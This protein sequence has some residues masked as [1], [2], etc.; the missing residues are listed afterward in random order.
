MAPSP[1][2]IVDVEISDMQ[3]VDEGVAADPEK[4]V[5]AIFADRTR[6]APRPS[7]GACRVTI[8]GR[9]EST[10]QR[11]NGASTALHVMGFKPSVVL[12]ANAALSA[13]ARHVGCKVSE[14]RA[15]P[16]R[17]AMMDAWNP[18]PQ[19]LKARVHD[20]QRVFLPT[21]RLWRQARTFEG[22]I[23]S[24]VDPT[25]QFLAQTN[26]KASGW[27][28]STSTGRVTRCCHADVEHECHI[29]HVAPVDREDVA[30]L[31]QLSFDIECSSATYRF[32]KPAEQPDDHVQQ[33][34]M[35][36][37]H[38]G[39]PWES[40]RRVALCIAPCNDIQAT[41]TYVFANE[42][43]LLLGVRDWITQTNPDCIVQ[44]NGTQFDWK[45]LWKRAE[46]RGID[47]FAYL[48][49]ARLQ[50][51]R[52]DESMPKSKQKGARER[53]LPVTPGRV[54]IDLFDFM[55]NNRKLPSYKL[56]DIAELDL[57]ERKVD[58]SEGGENAYRVLNRIL[59]GA[60]GALRAKAMDYC[61]RDAELPLLLAQKNKVLENYANTSRVTHTMMQKVIVGGEG[62]KSTRINVRIMH[63]LDPPR[64]LPTLHS[65]KQEDA[66]YEGATVI[67]PKTGF[68]KQKVQALDFASLYPSIMLRYNL[69][70]STLV[71][72]A[73]IRAP[74]VRAAR[75][76]GLR[77]PYVYVRVDA[78]GECAVT[79]H[80][81]AAAA[82]EPAL[83]WLE[84]KSFLVVFCGEETVWVQD[85]ASVTG[86]VV[87]VLNGERKRVRTI[88]EDETD[89]AM[90]AVLDAQQKAFKVSANNLYGQTGASVG[91]LQCLEV[92]STVTFLGRFMIDTTT[93][94]CE[95][96]GD[97]EVVYGDTDSVFIRFFDETLTMAQTFAEA[98]AKCAKISAYFGGDI[99]L[100]NEKCYQPL[101]LMK[102]K[103]Y[104]G[105][106][107]E[108]VKGEIRFTKIEA[109]GYAVRN[110]ICQAAKDMY[111]RSYTT[112][113]DDM[114][115]QRA[116]C[117]V[118]EMLQ[119]VVR[120]R[121][122][123]DKYVLSRKMGDE[124]KSADL[125]HVA[126]NRELVALGREAAH[127]GDRQ[128]YVYCVVRGA[129]KAFEKAK[130]PTLAAERKM[131]IDRLYYVTNQFTNPLLDLFENF[132]SQV[133][134]IFDETVRQI[135]AD[136]AWQRANGQTL[137]DLE[138]AVEAVGAVGAPGA[139]PGASKKRS[140]A[141]D[142]SAFLP[143]PDP[144]KRGR[145]KK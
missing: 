116:L 9:G 19:T 46:Q 138:E 99:K 54:H 48:S 125:A 30:P 89:P 86:E 36:L 5:G 134:A 18:D 49:R 93:R 27:V 14:L 44:Y 6:D 79:F 114:E 45:W 1:F 56:D 31:L 117:E 83:A 60:D 32:P 133:Q 82:S 137:L 20:L 143:P 17:A 37:W 135:E 132:G 2:M 91:N 115:P 136:P 41:E 100:E 80:D 26:L 124:Y 85:E 61:V 55:S 22:C 67:E 38:F 97:C 141:W 90:K 70:V 140:A 71:R 42:D 127:I 69:C 102:K 122:P 76:S 12:P 62:Q 139:A 13:V 123:I 47:S 50:Q 84:G 121:L 34:S 73:D 87:R 128:A 53:F 8:Y 10:A 129:S 98:D 29:S 28:Q 35:V 111:K 15:V 51:C 33:V 64:V 63:G 106:M 43:D 58:L 92:A 109:K 78:G 95:E 4:L 3:L 66:K 110:D 105:K 101:N 52:A 145:K 142:M 130:D 74:L 81:Q 72:D 112:L 113:M 65:T 59:L 104:I 88:M 119:E 75:A 120:D 107:Y 96:D 25:T 77:C 40:R 126:V 21:V 57:G 94:L 11:P 108:M 24:M 144:P 68:Y 23:E 16:E 131:P 118:R 103:R 7:Y 39:T